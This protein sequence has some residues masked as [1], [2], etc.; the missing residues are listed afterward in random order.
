MRS[1]S[2]LFATLIVTAPFGSGSSSADTEVGNGFGARGFLPASQFV[3][4]TISNLQDR[5]NQPAPCHARVASTP[6]AA[7]SQQLRG[8]HR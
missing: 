8:P 4:A 7:C 2:L 5:N 6:R 3:Q 1:P